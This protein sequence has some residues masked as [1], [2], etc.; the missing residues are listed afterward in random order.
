MSDTSIGGPRNC[1][2]PTELQFY[3][4]LSIGLVAL[5]LALMLALPLLAFLADLAA[6][7]GGALTSFLYGGLSL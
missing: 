7:A 4:S 3:K 2:S 6:L 5:V 1:A